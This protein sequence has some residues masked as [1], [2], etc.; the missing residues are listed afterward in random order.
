VNTA[1]RI[2][3]SVAAVASAAVASAALSTSATAQPGGHGL[4]AVPPR[5]LAEVRAATAPFHDPAAAIAAGYLPSDHCVPGMGQHWVNP[6]NLLDGVHDARR[7]DF[8]L[9]E[10]TSAG[11]RLV[12]VEWFQADDDQDLGTD[13]DR[14]ELGGG[15]FD[16]PM[17]GHEPGMPTHYDLHLYVWKHNPAGVAAPVN[18][19]VRC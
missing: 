1:R 12:G 9:Y 17:L 4:G 15:P 18:P 11:P 8:L 16:G 5:L 7:P 3:V 13:H 14:P 6:D 10:P 19:R 2:T